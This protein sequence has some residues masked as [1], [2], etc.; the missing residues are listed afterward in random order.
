MGT[1]QVIFEVVVR[2]GG[3]TGND[4]VHMRNRK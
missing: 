4:R 3:A 2:G 1:A